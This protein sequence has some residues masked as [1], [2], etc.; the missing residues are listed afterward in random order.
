[1]QSIKI[2]K[3]Q[4]FVNFWLFVIIAIFPF[5]YFPIDGVFY[6]VR[7]RFV[8]LLILFLIFL[9]FLLLNI[10]HFKFNIKTNPE[11]LFLLAYYFLA[12]I[13]SFL[14]VD[15]V[16]SF[17]G[18][19]RFEGYIILFIYLIIYIAT[20]KVRVLN[21]TT[22]LIVLF[23]ASIICIH[24]IMQAYYLDP[25]P[26]S[27]YPNGF[28]GLAFSTMSNPNF[29]GSFIA[30]ILPFTIYMYIEKNYS[31]GL[32]LYTILFYALLCTRT[33]G[34]WVGVLVSLIVYLMLK[35]KYFDISTPHKSKIAKIVLASFLSIT[36][37]TISK[38]F[39]FIYRFL[40]IF[41]EFS[42]FIKDTPKSY[43]GGSNRL[44]IWGRIL[45]IIKQRPLFG[46]GL[47]NLG[48][49]MESQYR[50]YMF[51]KT[52]NYKITDMAHN[53]Y[54]HIAVT[55][56][57]PSLIAYLGFVFIALKKSIS[58]IKESDLYLPVT[59]S[60]IGFFTLSMFN[61]SLIMFEYLVW[62]L[63]G[64]ATATNTVYYTDSKIELD[65]NLEKNLA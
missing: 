34:S 58:R 65:M 26:S 12:L 28:Y 24:A 31:K 3:K 45:D 47:E 33:R 57:I 44:V 14:A 23:S 5:I 17:I 10:N 53:E 59:A 52:G 21:K 2:D 36:I 62:M 30:L 37:V 61:N 64:I 35:Y 22:I 4:R 16:S 48:L 42:N 11:F 7:T 13:S 25:F 27:M 20:K 6:G 54:L 56:G 15:K 60:L 32:I 49:V 55:T 63:L 43:L 19:T 51:T 46:I 9:P 39:E 18:G 8:A 40:S 1:M 29:L 38:D 41:L 50:E